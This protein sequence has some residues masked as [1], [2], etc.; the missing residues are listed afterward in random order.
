[1][2]STLTESL[3]TWQSWPLCEAVF[4]S[5]FLR[6]LVQCLNEEWIRLPTTSSAVGGIGENNC[7]KYCYLHAR[8]SCCRGH[9]YFVLHLDN[10]SVG[11]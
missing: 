7:C 11:S 10:E 4:A 8:V 1:M 6:F 9:L 2:M 5:A 3:V